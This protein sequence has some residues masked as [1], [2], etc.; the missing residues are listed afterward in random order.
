MAWRRVGPSPAALRL[1]G[2]RSDDLTRF[3][4]GQ[5][6]VWTDGR[7]VLKP[8]G[9]SAEHRFVCETYAGWTSADVRVPEPVAP[10]GGAAG[11]TVD[12][13]GAHV[14]MPG[15]D[16]DPTT[17][18]EAIR[19]ACDAFHAAVRQHPRPD[20]LD[21]RRDPWSYG[22]R[23]AWEGAD[24]VGDPATLAVVEHLR[25]H[26]GPVTSQDQVIHGDV[27]PNV[28]VHD[29]VPGVIDWPVYHRPAAFA[30]AVVVTDAVTFRGAALRL[31][32]TW[33][34]GV[35]WQQMLVRALLYRLG[36]T[37]VFARHRRLRGSLVTH[38]ERVRPV[39]AAVVGG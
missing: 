35:D 13:W 12:G 22:D 4:G 24:P 37:G 25:S 18:L 29:G 20:F 38:L 19:D 7:L 27:L 3:P 11:W 17:E 26:L 5:G 30:R 23:L 1:F 34:V 28:L 16:A 14:L 32:E 31:L 21:E 2:V 9:T 15:R 39:V 6:L 36:P 10:G 8:V 33:A